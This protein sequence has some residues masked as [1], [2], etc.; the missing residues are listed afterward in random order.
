ML[1]LEVRKCKLFHTNL[2]RFYMLLNFITE[3]EIK[4]QYSTKLSLR[5]M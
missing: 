3:D 4:K 5:Y 2:L 1:D